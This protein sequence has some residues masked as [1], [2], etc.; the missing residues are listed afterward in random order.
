M[1]CKDEEDSFSIMS[2]DRERGH[3]SVRID[4][5]APF[6]GDDRQSFVCWARQFEVSVK[7]LTEG[8]GAASYNYELTRILPTRLCN[9]AFSLWDSLS[10]AVKSDYDAVKEKL[11]EAF[12][13]R[14]FMERFRASLSAR[15]RAARESLEVY[16]AEISKLVD[17]AFPEYGDRA[18]REEKF[19]R[20][21]AGLDPVLRTKCYE[22]GAT[23]MEEAVTIAGRCENARNAFDMGHVTA[24]VNHSQTADGIVANVNSVS[25]ISGLYRAIDR[26]TDEVRGMKVSLNRLEDENHRLKERVSRSGSEWSRARSPSRESSQCCCQGRAC[27]MQT[28][29]TQRGRSSERKPFMDFNGRKEYNA[30]RSPMR[31]NASPSPNPSVR[32]RG[33]YEEESRKQGVRFMTPGGEERNYDPGN[34]L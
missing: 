34:G 33:S 11:K 32:R 21:V 30:T 4:L 2:R 12:G 23:D 7:A 13:R 6:S 10:D 29:E 8:S 31:R 22:Q 24:N 1:W 18:Q 27:R 16:A 15:P 19:R 17:E 5:P 14:Q 26:L 20:F 3:R 25:D 28:Y 9:A